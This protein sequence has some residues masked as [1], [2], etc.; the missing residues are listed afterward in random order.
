MD[1]WLSCLLSWMHADKIQEVAPHGNRLLLATLILFINANL[2]TF[3]NYQTFFHKSFF[4]IAYLYFV[5]ISTEIT[6]QK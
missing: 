5:Q 2:W 4:L 6:E 3:K 1:S